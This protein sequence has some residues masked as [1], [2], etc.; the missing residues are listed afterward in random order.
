M[1]ARRLARHHL[2]PIGC[3]RAR[4]GLGKK[5]ISIVVL[6][7]RVG[8]LSLALFLRGSKE[9]ACS[10]IAL[11]LDDLLEI[12]N[13][14]LEPLLLCLAPGSSS[15]GKSAGCSNACRGRHTKSRGMFDPRFDNQLR[16]TI[17]EE[18]RMKI[19]R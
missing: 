4:G 16:V 7:L 13:P 3:A 14:L 6:L 11:P 9:T 17:A 10:S 12:G 2:N 19:R 1:G 5:S 15:T 8:A 18:I